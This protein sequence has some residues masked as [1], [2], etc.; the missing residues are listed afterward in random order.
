MH[1]A[2]VKVTDTSV[3]R[4]VFDCSMWRAT[5]EGEGGAVHSLTGCHRQSNDHEFQHV[6]DRVRWGRA[7]P[8]DV[9]RI[10]DTWSAGFEGVMTKLRIKKSAVA[11]INAR[12][13]ATIEWPEHHFDA[14]DVIVQESSGLVDDPSATLR[15][16][17]DSSLSLKLTAAVILTQKLQGIPAGSRGV[18]KDITVK[19]IGT[20][21]GA[22]AVKV[23]SCDFDGRVIGIEPVRFSAFDSEGIEVAFCEQLPLLLRW[24]VTVHRSQGMTLVAVEI[25]FGVGTWSTCGLVYTALSRVRSFSC[26]CVRGLNQGLI[27]VS[28]CALAYYERTLQENDV[29]P[30]SDGRPPLA[31]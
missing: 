1:A 21:D 9:S 4:M 7:R 11:D 25:D 29:D 26:L 30:S 15:S 12:Q 3:V 20:E 22:R 2:P 19:K 18:V 13:L 27:R 24:A 6:L 8:S 10:N 5:F 31:S 23:V 14:Q 28:R 16:L 17:G